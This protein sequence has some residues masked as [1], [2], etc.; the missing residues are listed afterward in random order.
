M[1]CT[2]PLKWAFA[3]KIIPDNLATGLTRFSVANKKRG[4]LAPLEAQ[5]LFA[6]QWKDRR[7]YAAS[8]LACTTGMRS[9]EVLA[10]RQEDIGERALNVRHSWSA[11]DGLKC[12]KTGEARRVP[13]QPKVM[14]KLLELARENPHGPGGFIFYGSL[15]GKPVDGGALLDG[16]HDALAG[17]GID[18]KVRGIVF[19]SWRHYYAA[20][21]ADRMDADKVSRVTGHKSRAVFDEY[22]DH[23]TEEKKLLRSMSIYSDRDCLM[24][25]QI[26]WT[27]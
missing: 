9:G 1:A 26:F 21:M 7:A 16:L 18:S 6:A 19:H 5:A 22:A 15:P 27:Q 20:R 13:L 8:L 17:I 24:S 3:Q 25:I 14:E 2:T 12:P 23:I 10:L 4:V 11:F